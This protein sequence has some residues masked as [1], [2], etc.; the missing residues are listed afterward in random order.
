MIKRLCLA[1]AIFMSIFTFAMDKEQEK[2]KR[3]FEEFPLKSAAQNKVERARRR[4]QER[5]E[6]H[7][8][9]TVAVQKLDQLA[10]ATTERFNLI[11][12]Q[13]KLIQ[14]ELLTVSQAVAALAHKSEENRCRCKDKIIKQGQETTQLEFVHQHMQ[15][16]T[17]NAKNTEQ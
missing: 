1:A 16:L 17:L 13:T 12:Q 9:L 3:E 15:A 2:P 14:T 11:D 4:R 5:H 8:L 6:I 7:A 10:Q